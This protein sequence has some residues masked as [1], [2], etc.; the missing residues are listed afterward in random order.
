MGVE[1]YLINAA[2]TAV[3]SQ[4]LVRKACEF[5]T[6]SRPPLEWELALARSVDVSLTEVREPAGCDA[7]GSTGF[8]GRTG[9]Y[10]LLVMNPESR[11]WI[12]QRG[13]RKDFEA[14]AVP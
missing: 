7:C 8:L 10:E 2:L 14:W 11:D 13:S 1:P 12:N 5:C 6:A 9:I 4:R 3:V